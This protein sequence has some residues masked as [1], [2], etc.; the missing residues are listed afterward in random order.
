[1]GAIKRSAGYTSLVLFV[2]VMRLA[3]AGGGR[4]ELG[5][6]QQTFR[7]EARALITEAGFAMP[8]NLSAPDVGA[9]THTVTAARLQRDLY[10]SLLDLGM[11]EAP[12]LHHAQNVA[13]LFGLANETLKEPSAGTGEETDARAD[14]HNNAQGYALFA[15]LLEEMDGSRDLAAWDRRIAEGAVAL[16]EDGRLNDNPQDPTDP[17]Y[18]DWL[19]D[20]YFRR[21]W[22]WAA[23]LA[24]LL[25][26]VANELRIK[27]KTDRAAAEAA[28]ILENRL[29]SL[30][31][32]MDAH[33]PAPDAALA[34]L[35]ETTEA[36]ERQ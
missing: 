35:P 24:Y 32:W 18:R 1:M 29:T 17:L 20:F 28:E 12:A 23:P 34:A 31:A 10:F 19:V 36:K 11:D 6:R 16:L 14:L 7:D 15:A 2:L 27:G 4:Q 30:T 8:D 33:G 13:Y 25:L 22:E 5:N 26:V 21:D 3:I 9:L